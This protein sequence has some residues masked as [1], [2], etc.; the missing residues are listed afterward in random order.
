[1]PICKKGTRELANTP[2]TKLNKIKFLFN[3]GERGT[4]GRGSSRPALRH[5]SPSALWRVERC[6]VPLAFLS[7]VTV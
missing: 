5:G 4:Q 6:Q 7:A 2:Y 1:M 3:L